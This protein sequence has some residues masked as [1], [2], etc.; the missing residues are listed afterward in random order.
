MEPA[1][2]IEA[3]YT[4]VSGYELLQKRKERGK[5]KGKK[6]GKRMREKRGKRKKMYFD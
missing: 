1:T 3:S 5:K 2:R 4:Q 6:K